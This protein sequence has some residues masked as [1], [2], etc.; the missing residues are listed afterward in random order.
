MPT[1][2]IATTRTVIVCFPANTDADW[3]T[4][5]EVVQ[6]H[7]NASG[8]PVRRFPV[9][10]RALLGLF[11]RWSGTHLLDARRRFGAV[12]LAAG[13]R[14][15]RL[16]LTST[17]TRASTAATSRWRSWYHNIAQ[18]TPVAK[19]WED[20]LTQHRDHPDKLS[21]DEARRRFEAQPRVLAMIAMSDHPVAQHVFDPYEL[22]AYQAGE[23]TYVTLHW[24]TA[25]GGDALITAEGQL[26]Q[27]QSPSLADRL[28]S[29]SRQRATCTAC[30]GD[31]ACA[32]SPSTN[33]H[34]RPFDRSQPRCGRS[35]PC[36]PSYHRNPPCPPLNTRENPCCCPTHP[37]APSPPQPATCGPTTRGASTPPTPPRWDTSPNT[38]TASP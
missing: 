36:P 14:V 13:G 20:F 35:S 2:A 5:S 28:R 24:R 38:Y 33:T 15:N 11:S 1:P 37:Y 19:P 17:V 21:R 8:T 10:H 34:N 18:S 3:F 6:H 9:R 25:I 31:S 30:A 7:L 4:A 23:A 29:S 27:P 32:Q 26:L 22:D 12:V 16:N